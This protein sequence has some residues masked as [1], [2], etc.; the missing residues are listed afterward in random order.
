MRLVIAAIGRLKDSGETDLVARYLKRIDQT[1]RNIGLGPVTVQELPEARQ[2]E[3]AQRKSD[4]AARLI[5]ATPKAD[6]RIVLDEGGRMLSSSEFAGLL[7]TMRDD[8]CRELAFLIGG[9]DGHGNAARDD[10]E[11]TLSLS[12]MTLPHGLARAVLAEQL[13]RA[14]TIIAG[15]PY[16]RA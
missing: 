13:Y 14:L 8:G 2:S 5:A 16:H 3:P 11:L 1:G 7:R 12:R 6:R 9:P 15:H 4:E 10:T